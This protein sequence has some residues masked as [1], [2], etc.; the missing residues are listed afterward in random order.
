MKRKYL[1][2]NIINEIKFEVSYTLNFCTDK[3]GGQNQ[4]SSINKINNNS[5]KSSDKVISHEDPPI[6]VGAENL[7]DFL[8]LLK[9]KYSFDMMCNL[10]AVDYKD[11]FEIV[12]D[13]VSR[14][15]RWELM[16]KVKLDRQKPQIQS[17]T[18]LY[19]EADFQEREQYDLMGIEFLNHHNLRRILLPDDFVGHP[20]RKDFVMNNKQ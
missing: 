5:K 19:P 3:D 9:Q 15:E 10:T 2:E 8:R 6:I 4:L 7:I 18:E 12:Y 11:H 17:V 14:E 1:P 13:L 20:L 16:V